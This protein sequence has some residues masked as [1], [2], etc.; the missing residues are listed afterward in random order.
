MNGIQTNNA[1]SEIVLGSASDYAGTTT[2]ASVYNA[3]LRVKLGIANALPTGTV[4]TLNGAGTSGTSRNLQ[5]DLNGFDQTVGGLANVSQARMQYAIR[6]SGAT[7]A[8]LTVSNVADCTYSAPLW[9]GTSTTPNVNLTKAG[10]GVLTLSG[11]SGYSGVTTVNGGVL[12][13]SD[14]ADGAIFTPTLTTTSNNSANVTAS[15]TAGLAVGM[16]VMCTGIAQNKTIASITDATHFVLNSGTGNAIFSGNVSAIGPATNL[17]GWGSNDPANLV[18][19]GGTLQYTGPAVSTARNFTVG[20]AAGSAID[21]SGSGALTLTGSPTLSGTDTARTFTLTGTNTDDNTFAG[22]L[23]DNGTGATSLVKSG[24]GTWVLT[25]ANAYTGTTA[26][27]AGTLKLGAADV[28]P[29][30]SGK[31]NVLVTGN[32]D[33]NTFSETINGLS[34]AGTVDTVAGGTPTLTLGDNDATAT[35]SGAIKNT[36]GTLALTKIG[37]GTQTLGGANTYDGLTTVSAGTLQLGV[38]AQ[39]V[40]LSGAGANIQ[41]GKM[42]LEYSGTAPDV[43]PLLKASYEAIGGAWTSGQFKSTTADASH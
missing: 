38:A 26:V 4:L 39:S 28:I 35:F 6:N 17:G 37:S 21:A 5:F 41:G 31:G 18:L 2:F 23:G 1:D 10:A 27:T 19:N 16:V 24:P 13:V 20:T 25:G 7:A 42:I 8:T 9:F 12:S 29:N 32:L 34:G 14:L 22:A 3:R 40:V 30:G 15:S 43:R 33:L 36:A 11:L